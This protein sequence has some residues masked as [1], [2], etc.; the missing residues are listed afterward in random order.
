MERHPA[1]L[2]QPDAALEAAEGCDLIFHCVGLPPQHYPQ[3]V[4][5]ARHTAAAM[6]E[7]A[8]RGLLVTSF[9]SYGPGDDDAMSEDRPPVPGSEMARIRKE[10]EDVL[11]EAGACVARLP[12]FYGPGSEVSLLNDALEALAAGKTALWPGSPDAPR[13]FVFVPDTG[14][15]LCDLAERSGAYG[16]PFNVPGSGALPPRT[17]LEMAA[18]LRDV[19]LKIRRGRR[20]MLTLAGLFSREIRGFKDVLPLYERPV[21]LDTARIRGLLGHEP[22]VTPYEE[23]L[24]QTFA[25]LEEP[26][27]SE[28]RVGGAA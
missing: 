3:H 7:H 15:L 28:T 1:D 25:W 8:A 24:Q 11:L 19:P 23:G 22:R 2:G 27:A 9:W 16:R 26:R 18:R 21:I 13:D 4:T 6:R 12:D 5:L 10:Q 17:I 20:W 14:R